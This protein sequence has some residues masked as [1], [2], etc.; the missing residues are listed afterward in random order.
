MA[1]Y[2]EFED[3]KKLDLRIGTIKAVKVHPDAE[4]LYILLVDMGEEPDRQ[5]VASLREHYKEDELI[6]KQVVVV[7]NLKPAVIRGIESNG[8]LL[9]AVNRKDQVSLI[10]T[11]RPIDNNSRVL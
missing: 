8:M 3:F 10:T 11:D 7:A 4:K 9:A 5:L 6:G 2:I 1:D